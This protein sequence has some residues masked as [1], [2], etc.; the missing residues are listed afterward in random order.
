[1]SDP[2]HIGGGWYELSDGSRIQGKGKALAIQAQLD[3]RAE[4]L[5]RREAGRQ[6]KPTETAE[7]AETEVPPRQARKRTTW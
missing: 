6:D 1:M 4:F 5:A 2:R 7:T 3:A